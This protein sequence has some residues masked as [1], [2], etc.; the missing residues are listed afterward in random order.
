MIEPT[1]TG[2]ARRIQSLI[3]FGYTIKDI[4][5]HAQ[6]TATTITALTENQPI[7]ATGRV[8]WAIAN[9]FAKLQMTPP[10]KPNRAALLHAEQHGWY[11]PFAWD[12]EPPHADDIGPS[13]W[14]DDP[15]AFANPTGYCGT[16]SGRERHRK[17]LGHHKACR[18][19]LDAC[20]LASRPSNE[21]KKQQR[22]AAAQLKVEHAY[23]QQGAA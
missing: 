17:A 9:T 23:A 21:A 18:A 8:R 3:A 10:P 11:P 12:E 4:S 13:H 5:T 15:H 2:T 20:A 6:V 16:V 19:C 7:E 1:T 14:I 22:A